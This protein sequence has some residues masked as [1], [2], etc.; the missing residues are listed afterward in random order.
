MKGRSIWVSCITQIELLSYHRL[1]D[2]QDQLIRKFLE[3]CNVIDL[4]NPVREL[5][6]EMRKELKLKVPDAIIAAT[7]VYLD[8]PLVTLDSDF[9]K[10]DRLDAVI[11]E[12]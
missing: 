3:E 6:I 12:L 7:S 9:G 5:T 1:S 2:D 4:L 10:I 11:L 8:L